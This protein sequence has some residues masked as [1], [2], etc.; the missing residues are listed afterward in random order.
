MYGLVERIIEICYSGLK[1][2]LHE[3]GLTATR[4]EK[5]LDQ[6]SLKS[7]IQNTRI[8]RK[9]YG[10]LGRGVQCIR[11]GTTHERNSRARTQQ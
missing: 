8:C 11:R 2:D 4:Q 3:R 6:F 10:Y 7:R 1:S 9:E 5:G